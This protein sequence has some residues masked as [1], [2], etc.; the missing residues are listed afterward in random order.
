MNTSPYSALRLHPYPWRSEHLNIG[1]VVFRTDGLR[2]HLADNLKKIRAFA[3]A[4]DLDAVRGWPGELATLLAGYP[5]P[6]ARKT[7][8]RWGGIRQIAEQEGR[9][10][11]QDEREYAERVSGALARLVDPEPK[12]PAALDAVHKSRLDIEL[13]N[14]FSAYGW[15]GKASEDIAHHIIPRYVLDEATGL[16]ADFAIKTERMN[17]I[18]TIDFR[19]TDP[20]AKRESAQAKALVLAL[21]KD[22]M[23]YAI[24][25]G[26]DSKDTAPSLRLL[27]SQADQLIRWEDASAVN[28]FL[29]AMSKAT[30]K[31]LLALATT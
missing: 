20:L 23:R 6:L 10:V 16:R 26:G 5:P 30:G 15:L 2:I 28:G 21:A 31:P 3:P 12:T 27:A 9:F 22:T 13:K 11:W 7:L 18:E 24:V 1:I 19:V 17:I 29:D 14:A 25:A 4:I 8:S